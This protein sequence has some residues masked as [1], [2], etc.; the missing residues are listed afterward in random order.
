MSGDHAGKGMP[1]GDVIAC[2]NALIPNAVGVVIEFGMNTIKTSLRIE[3]F[4][5]KA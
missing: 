1:I 4:A 5:L 3:A 2:E